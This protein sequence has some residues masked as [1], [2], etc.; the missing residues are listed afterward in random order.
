MDYQ[1][2]KIIIVT[3]H[4]MVSE[5][6]L[7]FE[8]WKLYFYFAGSYPKHK[9]LLMNKYVKLI[10][11]YFIVHQTFCIAVTAPICLYL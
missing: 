10:K 2:I 11:R 5:S 7:T 3:I 4:L 9:V 6:F 1:L 8:I